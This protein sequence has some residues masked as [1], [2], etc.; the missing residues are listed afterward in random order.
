MKSIIRSWLKVTSEE[1]SGQQDA[2]REL[3]DTLDRLEPDRARY[4]ARFAYL[5]GRVA[6]ADQHVSPDETR[7]M[8]TLIEREGGIPADQAMLVIGL[9]KS[10]N[11]LFGG[12][13]NFLVARDFAAATTHEQKLALL[14]CLFA[15]SAVEGD[16][17]VME[18]RE[19]RRIAR[20]LRIEHAD[21]VQLRLEY[22]RHLPGLADRAKE[23]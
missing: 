14:R 2:L 7:M 12:T 9:A 15:V 20:E 18:E 21:L 10:S 4:L 17:S 11:L 3:L 6:H 13:D 19:I 1:P 5:L 23:E 16:I 8:E 22:R